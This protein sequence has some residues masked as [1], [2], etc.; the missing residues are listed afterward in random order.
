MRL[1]LLRHG[2]TASNDAARFNGWRD[3]GL[4][5]AQR[6]RL[7]SVRFEWRHYDVVYCSPLARCVETAAC[8]GVETYRPEPRI[9]ERGLGIFEGLTAE[10]C[11]ARHPDEFVR[12][13]EF[14]A[15]YRIPDG[16]SRADNLERV[17]SWLEEASRFERVLAITHGGTI[18]FVFRLATGHTLHGGERIFAGANAALSE[19]EVEWPAVRLVEFARPL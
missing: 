19:F 12:F 1:D 7:A 10:E 17:T 18:D 4:T 11:R 14:D 16:E 6:R 5:R 13:L 15:D 2:I 9:V 8:L 3:D